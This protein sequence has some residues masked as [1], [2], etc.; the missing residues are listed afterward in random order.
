MR[1]VYHLSG[2]SVMNNTQ[3]VQLVYVSGPQQLDPLVFSEG[4][5]V[6]GRGSNCDFTLEDPS[7]SISRRHIELSEANENWSATDLGSRNGTILNG[8]QIPAKQSVPMELGST[9]QIGPWTFRFMSGSPANGS[10]VQSS[11]LVHTLNDTTQTAQRF[12]RV[13]SEPLAQLASHRLA[14]LLECSDQIHSAVDLTH[15]CG[16]ALNAMLTST[17]YTR[18]AFVRPHNESGMLETLAFESRVPSEDVSSVRFSK[19]LLEMAAEGEVVRLS[20]SGTQRDYGQ[21]I[22]DLEIHSAICIPVMNDDAPIGFLYLDARGSELT[23][24]QDASSFGR[25]IGRLLGLTVA[26]LR[27]KE[28]E[29]HQMSM[30]FDLDIAARA[31]KLLLPPS[32]GEIGEL[33]YSMSMRPGRYVA[34]DLFG[35]VPLEDG[36]VCLFL[37]DVS[38]KGAGSAILMATTQ[39]YI[40]AMLEQT[41]DL[42]AIITRLNRHIVDRSLG[43]MFVTMWIGILNPL[44]DDSRFEI[45]FIDAGHGHWLVT[46]PGEVAQRPAY[47]G[48][49]VVG[50]DPE[51]QYRSE[52]IELDHTQRL[53]LFSDGVVEQKSPGSSEEFGMEQTSTLLSRTTSSSQDIETL[54]SAVVAYAKSA[55]LDDD[56]TIASVGYKQSV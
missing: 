41:T 29:I 32:D 6:L 3:N 49:L 31:Q 39:S 13:Q 1:V 4:T 30:Q 36:R 51:H 35:V 11:T 34:G 26:N 10:P 46:R 16:A 28:L 53:V 9:L 52:T 2:D 44:G 19:S 42:T 22:A 17:G 37:G 43:G 27:R 5:V 23:V 12:E 24:S 15:A 14:V 38:G 45:E 55:Q 8:E 56:M 50:I 25:A 7:G 47:I 18:G 21:S 40:H 33:S 20:S 54:V 48:G